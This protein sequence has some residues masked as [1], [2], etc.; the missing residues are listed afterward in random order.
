MGIRLPI[1]IVLFVA[2]SRLLCAEPDARTTARLSRL[3]DSVEVSLDVPYAATDDPRQTLNLLL[4]R[5]RKTRRLPVIV[6]IHGGA[7]RHGDK[8]GGVGALAKPV[9]SG[10]YA[11]V[12]VGYRL[13]GST[14]WPGQIHDCKA[15]IRWIRA[16]ADQ[17]GFD[18]D[19][20]GVMGTSAGGHLAAMLGTSADA[21]EMNGDVGAF[22]DAS[23]KVAC[24]VDFY[25]PVDLLRMNELALPESTFD[26]DAATSPESE[27]L[28]G[29]IHDR[30]EAARSASPL[31]Y[32]TPDDPP[33]FI[34]HGTRDPLV[35][36]GQSKLLHAALGNAGV[37]ST[38]ITVNRGLHGKNFG[39]D[40]NKLV[41]EFFAHHLLGRTTTWEDQTVEAIDR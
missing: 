18:P 2:M 37:E 31:T 28:G 20:I 10:E 40:T 21:V 38:L 19:R 26:H 27:L 24:V 23:S 41:D 9:A 7:W 25:G 4:P 17:H 33:F 39:P 30:R 34:L 15:A 13:S 14:I 35:G 6:Y 29:P 12:T 22:T 5:N 1:A 11:G 36:V 8:S 32:V 16:H 3:R